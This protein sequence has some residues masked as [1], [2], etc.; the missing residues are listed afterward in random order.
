ML[1]TIAAAVFTATILAAASSAIAANAAIAFSQA[2]G[3]YGYAVGYDCL[4]E[5]RCAAMHN[6]PGCD[7]EV[8]VWARN[9]W[10]ALAVGD[11]NG[12]GCAWAS[13]KCEA[14]RLALEHCKKNSCH[15]RIVVCVYSGCD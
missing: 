8:V 7:S 6:C 11:D 9:G 14:E 2:T 13:C 15:G 1:R 5:A 12:Y 10:C 3:N 4:P